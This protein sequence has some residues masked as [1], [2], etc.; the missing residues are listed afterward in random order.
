MATK[1]LLSVDEYLRGAFESPD[2]DYIEGELVARSMPNAYHSRIQIR[3]ADAFKPWEDRSLVFRASEIRLRISEGRFRVADFA[4]FSQPPSSPIPFDAPYAVFEIVSPDDRYED[5][6]NKLADYEAAGIEFVFVAD[7]ILKRLS[8]YL[9]GDLLLT[10]SLDM[11][12]VQITIPLDQ[13]FDLN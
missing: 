3:L 13:I 4:L 2:P 9:N 5:L 8:R 1:E 7:P 10:Y 12:S 11:P 6:M